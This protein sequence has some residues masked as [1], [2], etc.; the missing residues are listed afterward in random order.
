[1][2]KYT[3]YIFKDFGAYPSSHQV[4]SGQVAVH[5]R[6]TL[7][8]TLTFTLIHQFDSPINLKCELLDCG[9]EPEET[10]AYMQIPH[11]IQSGH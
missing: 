9:R 1:M 7:R 4:H 8:Q 3:T 11:R 2:M 6:V 5:H 10:Q